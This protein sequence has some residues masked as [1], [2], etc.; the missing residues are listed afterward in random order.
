MLNLD[1]LK[2]A[3]SLYKDDFL[4]IWKDEKFKWEA[5]KHFQITWDFDSINFYEMFNNSF[6]KHGNLLSGYNY[7]FIILNYIQSSKRSD[8]TTTY[9]IT[10][11]PSVFLIYN[12]DNRYELFGG[13][14]GKR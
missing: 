9:V 12:K 14:Y 7:Y 8:F 4:N 2:D 11:D 5:V 13:R 1:K 3:I 6:L 10:F